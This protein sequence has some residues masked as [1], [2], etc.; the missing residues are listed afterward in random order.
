MMVS[1]IVATR[2]ATKPAAPQMTT[3]TTLAETRS[4]PFTISTHVSAMAAM[5]T[6]D[7]FDKGA[8]RSFRVYATA[9]FLRNRPFNR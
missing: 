8:P 3:V 1:G 9:V 6:T 4:P 7:V 2:S 5:M